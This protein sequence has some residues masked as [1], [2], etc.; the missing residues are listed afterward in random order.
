MDTCLPRLFHPTKEGGHLALTQD[1]S[2][3]KN[4]LAHH[5]KARALPLES[6]NNPTICACR[7]VNWLT[8]RASWLTAPPPPAAIVVLM[9]SRLLPQVVARRGTWRLPFGSLLL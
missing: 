5:S 3:T 2:K 4:Q 9:P 6:V 7:L 1:R 8:Q